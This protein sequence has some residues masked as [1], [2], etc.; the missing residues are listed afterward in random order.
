MSKK[1]KSIIQQDMNY[2]WK[3]GA[4]GT[5]RHHCIKAANRKHSEKYGLVVGL[6]YKCHRGENGVHGKNGHK[7]DRYLQEEAQIAFERVHGTREDF[8]RIFGRNYL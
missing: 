2:C 6:C 8:I 3:C 1:S 7:L 4:F 5:E